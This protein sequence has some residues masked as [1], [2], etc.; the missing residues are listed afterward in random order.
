M[1]ATT[2]DRTTE[3]PADSADAAAVRTK[4]PAPMMA[5]TPSATRLRVVRV[6]FSSLWEAWF[7]SPAKDFFRLRLI[8]L[9]KML[10]LPDHLPHD[11]Q[12]V[13]AHDLLHVRLGVTFLP[14]S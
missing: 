2:K 5:P 10:S 8:L 3:G 4:R 6:R 9:P 1:A 7:S 14:E 11:A 12:E 13:A